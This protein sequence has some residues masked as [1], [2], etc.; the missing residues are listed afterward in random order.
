MKGSISAELTV[1]QQVVSSE[2]FDERAYSWP[3]VGR[4]N[5]PIREI[6]R[7][8]NEIELTVWVAILLVRS[9]REF[10]FARGFSRKAWKLPVAIVW[11]KSVDSPTFFRQKL[12]LLLSPSIGGPELCLQDETTG[13][14]GT[15]SVR[16]GCCILARKERRLGQA[17]SKVGKSASHAGVVIRRLCRNRNSRNSEANEKCEHRRHFDRKG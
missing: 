11:P 2:V 14:R 16:D 1:F 17:R 6:L 10:S 15:T 7:A 3:F 9:K 4:N 8:R 5:R 12:T 13:S